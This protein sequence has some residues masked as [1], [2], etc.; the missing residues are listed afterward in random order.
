MAGTDGD[1]MNQECAQALDHSGRKV[2]RA[3]RG[4]GIQQN[5]IVRVGRFL[6][7]FT[8]QLE[9]ILDDRKTAGLSAHGFDLGGDPAETLDLAGEVEHRQELLLLRALVD[10]VLGTPADGFSASPEPIVRKSKR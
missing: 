4:P 7:L 5:E 10:S 3:R 8:D 6:N 2:L 9:I 1:A